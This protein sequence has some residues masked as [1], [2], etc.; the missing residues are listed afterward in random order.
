MNHYDIMVEM[1]A[2]KQNPFMH[3]KTL[4]PSERAEVFNVCAASNWEQVLKRIKES[5][6]I[7]YQ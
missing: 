4:T 2:K 6:K 5:Y 3:W 7:R 1:L